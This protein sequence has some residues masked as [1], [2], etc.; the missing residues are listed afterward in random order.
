MLDN[1]LNTTQVME[2]MLIREIPRNMDT[3]SRIQLSHLIKRK[4]IVLLTL[5]M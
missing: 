4:S 3:L 1:T 5:M 2:A